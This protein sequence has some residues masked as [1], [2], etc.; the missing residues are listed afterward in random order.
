MTHRIGTTGIVGYLI[1][2]VILGSEVLGAPYIVGIEK[3]V[4]STMWDIA[5]FS[6]LALIGF[7]TGTC[8]IAR[9]LGKYKKNNDSNYWG[10]SSSRSR[11]NQP[12]T[13]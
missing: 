13:E 6:A 12:L 5:M 8:L 9:S 7:I 10:M 11:T 4:F 1:A 3:E 2:G